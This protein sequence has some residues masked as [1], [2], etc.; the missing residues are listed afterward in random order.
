MLGLATK[1]E[2]KD[3]ASVTLYNKLYISTGYRK[4]LRLMQF[5]YTK[6]IVGNKPTQVTLPTCP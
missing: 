1:L 5:H 6:G 2:I 4:M 3:R